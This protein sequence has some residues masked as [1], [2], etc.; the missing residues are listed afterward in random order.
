M[1]R[2]QLFCHFSAQSSKRRVSSVDFEKC[3]AK[4]NKC[5]KQAKCSKDIDPVCG[6]DAHTY[7]NK[8][9]LMIATCL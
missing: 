5:N 3:R 8:C 6:T 4:F 9:H 2:H 1:C 7:T